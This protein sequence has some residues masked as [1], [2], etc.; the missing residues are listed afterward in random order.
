MYS[1][2]IENRELLKVF[3][4]LIIGIISFIIVFKTDKLFRLSFHNGIRYFRNAFLFYG[5]AFIIRY[6]LGAFSFY[7]YIL[8]DYYFLINIMFEF[9]LVMAGFFLV[10]SLLWRRFDNSKGDYASSLL[11]RKISFFYFMAFIIVF[12]DYLWQTHYFMFIS[13]IILFAYASIISYSNYKKNRIKHKFPKF[14]FVAMLLTLI[15]WVLNFILALYF[16]WNKGILINVYIINVII[17]LLFLY[18]VIKVTRVK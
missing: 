9:F 8:P 13:Q 5:I 15:T 11:N 18:G 4:G 14:Y 2:I 3:Y 12:L 7:G 10:Y 6:L 1:W 17:F 16:N